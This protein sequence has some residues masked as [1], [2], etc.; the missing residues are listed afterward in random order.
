MWRSEANTDV[1][2]QVLSTFLLRQGPS[3]AA[4]ES[5]GIFLECPT[6]LLEKCAWVFCLQVYQCTKH[7]PCA[8]RGQKKVL[9]YPL[10]LEL[11]AVVSHH[12]C[13]G[14]GAWVLWK[15]SQCA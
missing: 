9:L 15:S 5:G 11:Q 12:V 8:Y 3:L 4:G 2:P 10:E 14:N 7:T 6:L 13:T 1:L